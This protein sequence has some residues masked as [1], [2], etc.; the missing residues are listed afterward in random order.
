MKYI[1]RLFETLQLDI[2]A[3]FEVDN[4]TL[5]A[6]VEADVGYNCS[7]SGGAVTRGAL[8][9]FGLLVIADETLSELTPV[10][11]YIA[12][13]ADGKAQTH[14]CTDQTRFA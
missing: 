4:T 3:W 10:Y 7:S 11:F 2:S 5:E 14:F 1:F 12:K 9:P 13:G 8:G 6:A